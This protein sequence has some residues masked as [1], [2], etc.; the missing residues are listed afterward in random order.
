MTTVDDQDARDD[1]RAQ[2]VAWLSH[3][4]DGADEGAARIALTRAM[5]G[6]DGREDRRFSL[7]TQVSELLKEQIAKHGVEAV[8]AAVERWAAETRQR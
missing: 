7:S 8:T 3:L 1:E 4:R 2:I 6:V 5:V